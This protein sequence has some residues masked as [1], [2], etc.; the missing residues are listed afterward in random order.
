VGTGTF[1][2]CYDDKGNNYTVQDLGSMTI[3]NGYNSQTGSNWSQTD[4][5]FGNTTITNGNAGNGNSWN[6]TQQQFGNGFSTYSGTD[7]DGNSFSGTCTKF[8]GCQ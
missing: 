4:T 6:M 8:G 7:S 5:T 2:T 1:R 3:T